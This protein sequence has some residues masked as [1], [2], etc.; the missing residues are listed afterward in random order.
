MNFPILFPQKQSI[1]LRYLFFIARHDMRR[2]L[3]LGYGLS[4]TPWRGPGRVQV[5]RRDR[6]HLSGDYTRRAHLKDMFH[7]PRH[8]PRAHWWASG[9]RHRWTSRSVKCLPFHMRTR[10]YI[11]SPVS[12]EFPLRFDFQ[13]FIRKL[14]G[15]SE[16]GFKKMM[17]FGK[18]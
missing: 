5:E 14:E 11:L 1:P 16:H 17:A 4:H 13:Q 7:L 15:S 9:P 12:P 18:K 8:I 3:S 10:L 2:N 6:R